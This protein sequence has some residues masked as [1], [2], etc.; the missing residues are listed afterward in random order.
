M[1]AAIIRYRREDGSWQKWTD[2]LFPV[3]FIWLSY[4][5][6]SPANVV[7]ATWAQLTDNRFLRMGNGNSTGGENAHR[8]DTCVGLGYGDNIAW[9]QGGSMDGSTVPTANRVITNT[10]RM[11]IAANPDVGTGVNTGPCRISSTYSANNVPEWQ[12]VYAWRR[13]A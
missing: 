10:W 1:A 3:G 8:H 11:S 2:H 6:T 13:T 12:M 9:I 5:N 7:G 4:T